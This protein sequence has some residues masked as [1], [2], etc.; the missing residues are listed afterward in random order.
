MY[1][2][3]KPPKLGAG[4]VFNGVSFARGFASLLDF[5]ENHATWLIDSEE[6]NDSRNDCEEP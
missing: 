3:A 2:E 5:V 4:S 6:A 1:F